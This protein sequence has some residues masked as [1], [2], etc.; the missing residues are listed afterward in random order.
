VRVDLDAEELARENGEAFHHQHGLVVTEL[1][2]VGE[3][4]ALQARS[5][6]RVE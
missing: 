4:Y 3:D 5:F 2:E 1:F 6:G